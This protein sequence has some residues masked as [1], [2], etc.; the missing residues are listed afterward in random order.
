MALCLCARTFR[1]GYLRGAWDEED[2]KAPSSLS[3]FPRLK[4]SLA[5]RR[6]PV[7]N[8]REVADVLSKDRPLSANTKK[9][10]RTH[11]ARQ[12]E[13]SRSWICFSKETKKI[14]ARSL[15]QRTDAE[16]FQGFEHIFAEEKAEVTSPD[17]SEIRQKAWT[18]LSIYLL[19]CLL[20]S[21]RLC[22]LF[23]SS[24][25]STR[26]CHFCSFALLRHFFLS[27]SAPCLAFF[28]FF[29]LLSD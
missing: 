19:I 17:F 18:S 2:K 16:D 15:S 4:F 14:S 22:N 21:L 5:V 9:D 26:F 28:S 24:V 10:S 27:F 8:S 12:R 29:L 11:A 1:Y 3:V 23:F 6:Q 7:Y 20:E 25:L 13:E